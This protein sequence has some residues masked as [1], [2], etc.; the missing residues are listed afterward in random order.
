M[1]AG[2]LDILL[3]SVGATTAVS[4]MTMYVKVLSDA[5]TK[6]NNLGRSMQAF[7]LLQQR[8][9]VQALRKERDAVA[10]GMKEMDRVRKYQALIDRSEAHIT[11][12]KIKHAQ[13]R[14][15]VGRKAIADDIAY[16]ERRV[17]WMRKRQG[18]AA[19]HAGDAASEAAGMAHNAKVSGAMAKITAPFAALGK[20]AGPIAAI[21][22]AFLAIAAAMLKTADAAA[23][24]KAEMVGVRSS[25][26]S[27]N[28]MYRRAIVLAGSIRF[29]K[30]FE[31]AII[32][33]RN[34]VDTGL[35]GAEALKSF[36]N[37]ARMV[38]VATGKDIA[39]V[40]AGL[41][42]YMQGNLEAFEQGTGVAFEDMS[43]M[44][45][46]MG[47]SINSGADSA[48][49][50]WAN[51]SDAMVSAYGNAAYQMDR[52]TMAWFAEQGRNFTTGWRALTEVASE[53]IGDREK[54]PG[55]PL[56]AS[57]LLNPLSNRGG[58]EKGS[59]LEE[60]WRAVFDSMQAILKFSGNI[61]IGLEN[62]VK[63]LHDI[64]NQWGAIKEHQFGIVNG[65][66]DMM[67]G[68]REATIMGNRF[69]TSSAKAVRN[70]S[71]TMQYAQGSQGVANPER[72]MKGFLS[73]AE[74]LAG[75]MSELKGMHQQ[76]TGFNELGVFTG[77]R[78]VGREAYILRQTQAALQKNVGEQLVG[79]GQVAGGERGEEMMRLGGIVQQGGDIK[80]VQDAIKR[81]AE[82]QVEMAKEQADKMEKRSVAQEDA[83]VHKIPLLLERLINVTKTG[84]GFRD[85]FRRMSP[86]QQALML[87]DDK[88]RENMSR[89]RAGLAAVATSAVPAGIRED[90]LR[91]I[92]E[93]DQAMSGPMSPLPTLPAEAQEAMQRWRDSQSGAAAGASKSPNEPGTGV[94]P[95]APDKPSEAVLDA[96]NRCAVS[97][98]SID[99]KVGSGQV[100]DRLAKV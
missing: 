42:A 33:L 89:E 98:A 7:H 28:K 14:T 16:T 57:S 36:G 41:T 48:E 6:M 18:F 12:S 13:A 47:R 25:L 19:G 93:I 8:A 22:T 34:F 52:T 35:S 79:Q 27:V 82:I 53:A 45:K 61:V 10:M 99:T 51:M 84:S 23:K 21:G 32:V 72:A 100:V 86:E 69:E 37:T 65:L 60:A 2:V 29:A 97:L 38:S 75:S 70:F 64:E 39:S 95:G 73:S 90:A 76:L 55:D 87:Q 24:N 3:R 83:L 59:A 56:S 50:R 94:T 62:Q 71:Q 43:R 5:S 91:G 30:G 58:Q 77:R 46:L 4:Q 68:L 81:A 67:L 66:D 20:F 85:Q 88:F 44:L 9:Q 92:A 54:K 40:S 49:R 78:A 80:T 17:Q 31:D 26:D 74:G 96:V 15:A 63:V 11:A 1:T